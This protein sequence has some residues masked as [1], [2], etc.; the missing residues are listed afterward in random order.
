MLRSV[1]SVHLFVDVWNRVGVVWIRSLFG[2]SHLQLNE[3]IWPPPH[4]CFLFEGELFIHCDTILYVCIYPC[5]KKKKKN[6]SQCEWNE[7]QYRTIDGIIVSNKK[8]K[9][10]IDLYVSSSFFFL[11]QLFLLFSPLLPFSF[12]LRC[13]AMWWYVALF[14][15]VE[16]WI[17]CMS[18]S[19]SPC[20][21]PY[22]SVCKIYPNTFPP[23]N[24]TFVFW[25]VFGW[26]P[27]SNDRTKSLPPLFSLRETLF[28][29]WKWHHPIHIK[30]QK[31]VYVCWIHSWLTFTVALSTRPTPLDLMQF[32]SDCDCDPLLYN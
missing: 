4:L 6:G 7:R 21:S 26:S 3:Q 12:V 10:S 13:D 14:L 5:W 19:L 32:C 31:S 24:L 11:T 8:R 25:F 1:L 27:S 30:T 17:P 2:W 20:M 23:P 18:S 28:D 15:C 22:Y 9:I 16:N 29:H